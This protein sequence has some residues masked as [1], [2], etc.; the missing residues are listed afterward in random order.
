VGASPPAPEDDDPVPIFGSWPRIYTAVIVTIV[1][2]IGLIAAF[3][4]FPY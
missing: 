2:V 4:S 3:S 1:V